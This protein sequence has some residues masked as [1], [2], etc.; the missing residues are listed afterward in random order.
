[1]GAHAVEQPAF[2]A[3]SSVVGSE[4]L[5]ASDGRPQSDGALIAG[6]AFQESGAPVT[7]LGVQ[8]PMPMVNPEVQ[9]AFD[10]EI[11]ARLLADLRMRLAAQAE[12]VLG[13][14]DEFRIEVETGDPAS[15]IVEAAHD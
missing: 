1:M 7:I 8:P 6:R 15:T 4:T 13:A 5:I 3:L 9:L 12:R 2:D 11:E 14:N 10:P